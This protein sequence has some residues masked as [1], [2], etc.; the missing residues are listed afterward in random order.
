MKNKCF[1]QKNSQRALLKKNP[2]G[3]EAWKSKRSQSLEKIRK[4]NISCRENL[5]IPSIKNRPNIIEINYDHEFALARKIPIY[6][7]K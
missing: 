1:N 7:K 3:L 4:L 2:V 6:N 5:I